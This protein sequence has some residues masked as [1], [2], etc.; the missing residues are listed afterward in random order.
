LGGVPFEV[1]SQ[2]A[3][4]PEQRA[5]KIGEGLAS[6]RFESIDYAQKTLDSLGM[7]RDEHQNSRARD[8]RIRH[9]GTDQ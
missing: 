3:P 7:Q 2:G 1:C 9:L 5:D 6:P 8:H 4:L